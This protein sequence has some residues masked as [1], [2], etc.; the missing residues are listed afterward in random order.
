MAWRS[1]ALVLLC[2]AALPGCTSQPQIERETSEQERRDVVAIAL[3]LCDEASFKA[4]QPRFDRYIW[5]R[6]ELALPGVRENCPVGKA[7]A[8]LV[9]VERRMS[10]DS[11]GPFQVSDY[12]VMIESPG[13]WS[14][15]SINTRGVFPATEVFAWNLTATTQRPDLL[16][17]IKQEEKSEG[18]KRRAIQLALALGALLA[19]L[20]AAR[21]FKARRAREDL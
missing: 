4:Q 18:Q 20:V 11:D 17:Q 8:K 13:K 5:R 21:W 3:S 19:V 2:G 14:R 16:T 15:A 9:K 10:G 12:I 7:D 1:F 6:S